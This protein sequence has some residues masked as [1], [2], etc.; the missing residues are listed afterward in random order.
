[1]APYLSCAGSL[2][3]YV[4]LRRACVQETHG[5]PPVQG[6]LELVSTVM[7]AHCKAR[8]ETKTWSS[9]PAGDASPVAPCKAHESLSGLEEDKHNKVDPLKLR[10][11]NA[12]ARHQPSR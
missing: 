9:P 2:E 8:A 7:S 3:S 11:E 12:R 6:I 10:L 5:V 4:H 1:M